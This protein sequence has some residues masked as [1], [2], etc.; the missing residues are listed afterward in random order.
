MPIYSVFLNGKQKNY[1]LLKKKRP[2][3]AVCVL[4]FMII[5]YQPNPIF[6]NNWIFKI[7]YVS[8]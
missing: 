3:F 2:C 5:P 7:K 1:F 4:L 8:R 6:L